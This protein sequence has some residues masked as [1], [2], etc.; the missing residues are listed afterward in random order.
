MKQPPIMSVII[1]TFNEQ[2]GIAATIDSVRQQLAPYRYQIIV[3]DSLSTDRTRTIAKEA[4]VTVVTLSNP[5]ERC[6]GVGHQLGY[7]HSQGKYLLLLDGDMTLLPGFIDQALS[8]LEQNDNYAGVA[9]TVEMEQRSSYEFK[10]RQQRHQKIYPLG[11]C[12]YLAGGGLYRKNAIDA[13]GYLTHRTL[14]AYEEAELG[15][16]LSQA[17]IVLEAR[18][19]IFSSHCVH[20]A[21]ADADEIPLAT[22][23]SICI[24]RVDKERFGDVTLRLRGPCSA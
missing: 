2:E 5:E 10:S 6:C 24:R 13:I 22:G 1:K 11:D 17:A 7:L 21:D 9:G 3:A 14:H 20:Y 15:M 19:A 4:G 16:R 12:D 23:L 8:F 18:H